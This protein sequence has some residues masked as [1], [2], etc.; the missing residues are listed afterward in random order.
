MITGRFGIVQALP[1]NQPKD[2][3]Q[4]IT[5]FKTPTDWLFTPLVDTAAAPSRRPGPLS[6]HRLEMRAEFYT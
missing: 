5:I 4:H 2:S 6:L 3:S 1:R